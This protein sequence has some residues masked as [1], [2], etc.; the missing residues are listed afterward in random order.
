MLRQLHDTCQY[1]TSQMSYNNIYELIISQ[2]L[3]ININITH[4]SYIL[5]T[6]LLFQVRA[7]FQ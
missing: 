7:T 4:L 6:V 2:K 1:Q 3:V 5:R